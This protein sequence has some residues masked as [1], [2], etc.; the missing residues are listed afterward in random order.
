MTADRSGSEWIDWGKEFLAR[1][2]RI[3]RIRF[4]S[5]TIDSVESLVEFLQTRAAYVAQ[6]ALYGYLK[7]RMGRDYVM[8]FKDKKFAPA[9]NQAKWQVYAACLSDLSVY[10]AAKVG[11]SPPEDRARFAVHCHRCCVDDTFIGNIAEDLKDEILTEFQQRCRHVV[12]GNVGIG[13]GAFSRSPVALAECSPV[14][15]E[16][17]KLDRE[18]VMNS[19]R[20]R[21]NDVREQLAKRLDG[22]SIWQEWRRQPGR[23]AADQDQ[24]T[25]VPD[26]I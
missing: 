19:V 20:F 9:L 11:S 4:D 16:F 23:V 13:E 12:W 8:I 6:T 17:R 5:S 10:A 21:W 24:S 1:F 7:T 26:V 15:D 2:I 14:S 18:I 25:A 3:F 22:D